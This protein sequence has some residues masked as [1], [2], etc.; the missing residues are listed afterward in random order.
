M[1]RQHG[2]GACRFPGA[3]SRTAESHRCRPG[4]RRRR[5]FLDRHGRRDD[6]DRL[7][8][9]L[10]RVR[11]QPAGRPTA[12][13][14]GIVHVIG[15][16]LGLTQPG[17]DDRLRRQPHVHARRARRDRVRHRHVAGAR[18]AGVAVPGARSARRCGASTSTARL[19]PG[20]YAKDVILTIIR[21]LGVQGGV[22]FALRVCGGDD[23]RRDDDRRAHDDLQHV[24]RRRRARRLRQPGRDDVRVPARARGSRRR[25]TAFDRAVAWWR[26]IASDARRG[27]TT[28]ACTFDAAVDRADAS[29]GAST[30]G[31]RSASAEPIAA[32]A[33]DE[34]L[35]FMG[36]DAGRRVAGHED[37]RRVHRLVHQRPAVGS[38]R[39]RAASSRARHVAPHVRRSSCPGRRR[40]AAAAEARG[41]RRGVHRG[42][43]RVA[44]RRLLDVPRR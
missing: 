19:A 40:S 30:P 18:R 39:G 1:L 9:Q 11:H 41:P 6:G 43:L 28:I 35:A 20:V 32:D 22:G 10:P 14:Q 27:A 36:F 21:R 7:E 42:R 34:A 12:T 25:A 24:D 17:H 44:R 16:E 29:P 23:D 4:T 3:P 13:N 15:P 2:L 33:D 5:P 8:A 38:R 26:Q 37:R 31:S